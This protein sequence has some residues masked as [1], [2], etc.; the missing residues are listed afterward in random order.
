VVRLLIADDHEVFRFGLRMLLDSEPDITVIGTA[1]DGRT[2]VTMAA[3]DPPDVVLMDLSMPVMDGVRATR[4]IVRAAPSVHV[5]VLTSYTR[6]SLVREVLAAG[7]H[8]YM[9]KG[10]SPKTLLNAIRSVHRG[11]RLIDP[12][13]TCSARSYGCRCVGQRCPIVFRP[14]ILRPSTRTSG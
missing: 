10:A 5:L 12:V 8:G 3:A 7:A 1:A 11:E 2:A 6:D 4:E 14:K 9:L 13:G